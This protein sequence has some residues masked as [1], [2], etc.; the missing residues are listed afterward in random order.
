M[1]KVLVCLL[2]LCFLSGSIVMGAEAQP[3]GWALD[4]VEEMKGYGTF[5][6]SSLNRFTEA[7]T[8]EDFIYFAVRI[9]ELIDGKEVV[10]DKDIT[11]LDTNDPYA[12]KAATV[13][14]TSG[15]SK[16]IFEPNSHLTREQLSVLMINTLKRAGI[17]LKPPS[18][19]LYKDDDAFSDWARESI[20][21]ARANGIISG[22]GEDVF[23]PKGKASIET[24]IVITNRI[25]KDHKL[26]MVRVKP[27]DLKYE[28]VD[29]AVTIIE[30]LG[31]DKEIIIPSEISGKPVKAIGAF[32]FATRGLKS[33]ELPESIT[34]IGYA[35]FYRNSL[36][37]VSLPRSVK[38]IGEMAFAINGIEDVKVPSACVVA[39]TAFDFS[40][41]KER[42]TATSSLKANPKEDFLYAIEDGEVTITSYFGESKNVVI[43]S[44][45][46]GLPVTAVGYGAFYNRMID[47]VVLGEFVKTIGMSAFE[48]STLKSVTLSPVLTEIE[49]YAF[50]ETSVKALELP[51]SIEMLGTYIF[52]YSNWG[53]IEALNRYH[54]N[55]YLYLESSKKAHLGYDEQSFYAM[56]PIVKVF[57]EEILAL[58]N[59]I[60]K[61]LSTDHEKLLAIYKWVAENIYYD[62]DGFYSN[63]YTYQD[64]KTTLDTRKGVCS[65]Y[66]L[67]LKEL[68]GAA[69]I[70]SEIV[71]GYALGVGTEG[72][73]KDD[74]LLRND[75]NH[76]WNRVYVN[77][78]W[79]LLDVTWDSRTRSENQQFNSSPMTL[80]YFDISLEDLSRSHKI[81]R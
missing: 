38:E 23:D 76:A 26:M 35:A 56:R 63:T 43:P 42:A 30:Y 44:T 69:G 55:R 7:I 75:T 19:Y 51:P 28:T 24:V 27:S 53:T 49:R 64:A 11:F 66:A 5:R 32:A 21:L 29:G 57:D 34:E 15:V 22:V 18:G 10:I 52:D 9:F 6:A 78:R 36:K 58:S 48:K 73:W 68:L 60:T 71:N 1:K 65:N 62:L 61:G 2:L 77:G 14:I 13:G 54:F 45:I 80:Y 46:E 3:S 8:R 81:I 79:M 16:G 41:K 72:R 25:V 20:Y 47:S 37:T 12:R 4:S 17:A 40:L 31:Q 50:L 74:I 70:Y 59:A 39:P 67:L 33:V